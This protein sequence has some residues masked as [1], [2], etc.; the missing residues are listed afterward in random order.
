MTDGP[1]PSTP[2][3][4]PALGPAFFFVGRVTKLNAE[5]PG[6]AGPAP[7]LIIEGRLG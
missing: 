2:I 1:L 6:E 7:A 3:A 5:S 4:P